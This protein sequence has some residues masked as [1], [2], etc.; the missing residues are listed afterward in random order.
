MSNSVQTVD[1]G[2]SNTHSC[3]ELQ[4]L[5]GSR[6]IAS[7]GDVAKYGFDSSMSRE[8]IHEK[9]Y[10]LVQ[11]SRANFGSP[12]RTAT[13][14]APGAARPEN[15]ETWSD[16]FPARKVLLNVLVR[17]AAGERNRNK[18]ADVLGIRS[19]LAAEDAESLEVFIRAAVTRA[20]ADVPEGCEEHTGHRASVALKA[21]TSRV[22]AANALVLEFD[23]EQSELAMLYCFQHVLSSFPPEKATSLR[24]ASSSDIA[25]PLLEVRNR[26]S[27]PEQGCN[28]PLKDVCMQTAQ[29]AEAQPLVSSQ[30]TAWILDVVAGD[31]PTRSLSP[32][33]RLDGR[34]DQALTAAFGEAD[35][36]AKANKAVLGELSI[37]YLQVPVTETVPAPVEMAGRQVGAFVAH[38]YE[39]YRW[40]N[41]AKIRR[42]V[43]VSRLHVMNPDPR[44]ATYD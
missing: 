42:R 15:V 16:E 8:T 5:L 21:F 10:A 43:A 23:L 18:Q 1:A 34:L 6:A 11:A 12:L 14:A 4:K 30:I 33:F 40:D 7:S 17:I 20:Q 22:R 44:D 29:F 31:N 19:M 36:Y 27:Q 41:V 35:K 2:T 25:M 26:L 37:C 28:P 13:F 32:A 38:A 39:V 3:D 9:F 24:I